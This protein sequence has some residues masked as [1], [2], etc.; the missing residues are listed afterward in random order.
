MPLPPQSADSVAQ[1]IADVTAAGLPL[2][3]GLR[4]A[5][6]EA[7]ARPTAAAL[8]RIADE[9]D[10]GRPLEQVLADPASRIPGYLNGLL[11]ATL[12]TGD[13]GTAF[14][15]LIDHQERLHEMRRAVWMALVYPAVLLLLA[16]AL[17]T[18]L[19]HGVADPF[20]RMFRDFGLKLP[21]ATQAVDWINRSGIIWWLLASIGAGF[22]AWPV[23]RWAAGPARWARA[24]ATVPLL[25]ALWFWSGVAEL[26]RLVAVLVARGIPLPEAL[27]L[28][29]VGVRDANMGQLSGLLARGVE[30]G[31]ALSDSLEVEGRMPPLV[32]PLVRWG[33]GTGRLAEALLTASDMY[34]GRVELRAE[35]LRAIL[36]PL[37]MIFVGVAIAGVLAGLAQ[38]L[39]SMIEGLSK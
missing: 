12:R 29:A 17:G 10:R 4:A 11:R 8:R 20:L 13:F 30:Q 27:E 15:E 23:V 34:A 24:L 14:L 5:A 3:E 36:P 16:L 28:A 6:A 26:T 32:T 31:R 25:G 33:E 37:L 22:V 18:F 9:L 2:A 35:M 7:D 1:S 21:Y 38:P 39:V 19:I